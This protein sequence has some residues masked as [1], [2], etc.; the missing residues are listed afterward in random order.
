MR[1]RIG[2][3]LLTVALALVPSA[4]RAQHGEVVPTGTWLPGPLG[5]PRYEEGGFFI[6]IEGLFW[7]QTNPIGNQDVAIRGFLDLDGSI[8]GGDPPVFVGSGQ[9]ALNTHQVSGPGTYQPGL[10]LTAGWR[11]RNGNVLT[12]SWMHLWD[13]RYS[14]VATLLP[15]GFFVGPDLENTFLFSPVSNFPADYAGQQRNVADGNLGATF[16]IWNAASLMQIEFLQ[17]FDQGELALRMPIWQT[18]GYR[19][20]GLIGPRIV[21]MHDRFKWRTVDADLNGNAGAEDVAIYTNIVSN[22]LYGVHCGM[23]HEWYLGTTPIGAFAC[24]VDTEAAVFIDFVKERAKYQLG[25]KSTAATRSR[26][27]Y[28]LV[29]EVQAKLN[30]WWYPTEAIQLRV[31]YDVMAF[32]NTVASPSPIDFNFGRIS[33]DWEKGETRFFRGLNFGISFVF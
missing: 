23:G 17:R 13:A 18:D 14:A 5:H 26:N 4:V 6:A 8:A 29:P 20:Y 2:G 7:K 30:L 1:T 11:F 10:N 33:P 28:T 3:F 16:G 32:F 24:S 25:D 31:G 15:P 19:N 22:R 12:L 21:T 9:V 27:E